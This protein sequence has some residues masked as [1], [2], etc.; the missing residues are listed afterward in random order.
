MSQYSGKPNRPVRNG[1]SARSRNKKRHR[2][3]TRRAAALTYTF[4]GLLLVGCGVLFAAN[5]FLKIGYIEIEGNSRYSKD[6]ITETTGLKLEQGMFEF[7][8]AKIEEALISTLG[9]IKSAKVSRAL[10]TGVNI[11]IEEDMPFACFETKQGFAVISAEGKVLETSIAER[12][13]N[14]PKLIGLETAE[15][16][17]YMRVKPSGE[18]ELCAISLE[19]SEQKLILGYLQKGL[20]GIEGISLIDMSDRL[21]LSLFYKHNTKIALGSE[22]EIAAKMRMALKIIDLEQSDKIVVDVSNPKK[23]HVRFLAPEDIPDD[24]KNEEERPETNPEGNEPD[25]NAAIPLT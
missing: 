11:T 18:S 17:A 8:P 3:R 14:M 6:L 4:V 19:N 25:E 22:G 7:N 12:P 20:A 9:Y 16:K 15:C 5:L 10:P 1:E 21:N 23:A 24:L 13:E 2:K